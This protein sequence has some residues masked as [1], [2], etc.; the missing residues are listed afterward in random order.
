MAKQPE[1]LKNNKHHPNEKSQKIKKLEVQ[2]FTIFRGV[3]LPA[4]S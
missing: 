4:V 2:H 3:D 1:N